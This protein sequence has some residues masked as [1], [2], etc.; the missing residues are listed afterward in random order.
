MGT[1]SLPHRQTNSCPIW[2]FLKM[3]DRSHDVGSTRKIVFKFSS[4]L[5]MPALTCPDGNG[6]KMTSA[7]ASSTL[8]PPPIDHRQ[9]QCRILPCSQGPQLLGRHHRS[10]LRFGQCTELLQA[11][12]LLADGALSR[13]VGQWKA[14]VQPARS[15][16]HHSPKLQLWNRTPEHPIHLRVVARRNLKWP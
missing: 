8:Y 1:A 11:R 5:A 12:G 3:G 16:Q 9:C 14:P 13:D 7:T 2:S 6:S 10:T 15:N 4:M